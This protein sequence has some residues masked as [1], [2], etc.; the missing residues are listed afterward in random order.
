MT[1]N[2][3]DRIA[4][5]LSESLKSQAKKGGYDNEYE[6]YDDDGEPCGYTLLNVDAVLDPRILADAVIAELGMTRESAVDGIS[7]VD[8]PPPGQHR[9]V[10]DWTTDD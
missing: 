2:L 9:Y 7:P 8:D 3:C 10:T 1:D 5:T 4:A 6:P